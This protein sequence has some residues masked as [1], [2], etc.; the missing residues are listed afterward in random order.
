MVWRAH[1]VFIVIS[2][3]CRAITH[4]PDIY[5]EPDVF[6]PERFLNPDGTLR[7]DPTLASVFGF[8]K[9]VCPGKYFVDDT[10]FIV[11]STVLSVFNIG[12]GSGCEDGQFEYSYIS[13]LVRCVPLCRSTVAN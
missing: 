9:R 2:I 11:T 5:P 3:V 12:K 6:K 8:G 10:L 13:S 4:D 7:D 1:A